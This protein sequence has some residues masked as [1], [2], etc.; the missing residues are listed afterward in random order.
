ME[1]FR[2]PSGIVATIN[3][4]GTGKKFKQASSYVH[5][6]ICEGRGYLWHR[7]GNLLDKTV[8][9]TWRPTFPGRFP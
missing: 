7:N 1:H 2:S 6:L 9:K 8:G 5:T 3:T 4:L